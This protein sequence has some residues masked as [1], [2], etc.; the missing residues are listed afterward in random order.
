MM[1]EKTRLFQNDEYVRSQSRANMLMNQ[2]WNQLLDEKDPGKKQDF[3]AFD[4][5]DSQW[6]KVEQYSMEW[7]KNGGRG[8]VG[9]I[10]LRQHVTVDKAH[11]G[12]PAR[13]LLGTLFDS[14]VTYVNG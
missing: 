8:I 14:D 13:L 1:V 10:W 11:A 5:D 7:A 4:Y 12:K 9:S 2:Q 3:T 6:R